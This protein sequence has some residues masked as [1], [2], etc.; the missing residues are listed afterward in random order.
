LP[1]ILNDLAFV[2]KTRDYLYEAKSYE[3]FVDTNIKNHQ[4]I[5]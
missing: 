2:K 4:E 1:R 5:A 3:D